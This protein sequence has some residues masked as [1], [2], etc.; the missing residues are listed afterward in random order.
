MPRDGRCV[1][2]AHALHEE[3]REG[4]GPGEATDG[5]GGGLGVD[6]V[7]ATESEPDEDDCKRG[8]GGVV[9]EWCGSGRVFRGVRTR[10]GWLEE[11]RLAGA[12][13]RVVSGQTQVRHTSSFE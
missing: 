3:G 4:E 9:W 8:C 5:G 10:R 13:R 11:G 2:R 6:D 7:K 1:E 12:E